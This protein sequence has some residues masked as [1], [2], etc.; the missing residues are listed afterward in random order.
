MVGGTTLPN[1]QIQLHI[2][3]QTLFDSEDLEANRQV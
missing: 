1:G 2:N 3:A